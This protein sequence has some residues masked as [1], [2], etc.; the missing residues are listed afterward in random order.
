[1]NYLNGLLIIF[2]LAGGGMFFFQGVRRREGYTIFLYFALIVLG[3]V[4]IFELILSVKFFLF[5]LKGW[6]FLGKILFWGLIGTVFFLKSSIKISDKKHIFWV[7]LLGIVIGLGL[8]MLTK[9]TAAVDWYDP[10]Q[11]I[12]TQYVDLLARNR[13]TRW[14]TQSFYIFGIGFLFY[15]FLFSLLNREKKWCSY[16]VILLSTVLLACQEYLY[17]HIGELWGDGAHLLGG[18]GIFFVVW[19]LH[20]SY[21]RVPSANSRIA[22]TFSWAAI[23]AILVFGV[24]FRLTT[25]GNICGSIISH[26]S[27]SFIRLSGQNVFSL[28]FF[29]SNRPAFI[30]FT[31]KMVGVDPNTNITSVNSPAEDIFVPRQVYPD[32]NCVSGWQTIMSIIS[33]STLAIFLVIKVQSRWLRAVLAALVLGFAY[34]PQL[35]DWDS[36]ILSESLSFSMWALTFALSMEVITR[37]IQNRKQVSWS[38]W[39][40]FILWSITLICWGFSRDTNAYMILLFGIISA[41]LLVIPGIRKLVSVYPLL[42]IVVVCLTSF[43]IQNSLLYRSDRWINPFFNNL[44]V[45]IL[46]YPERE[47]WFIE[48]GMPTPK[49]LYEV[50]NLLSREDK[51]EE[52]A[53]LIAWTIEN[54]S[55]LYTR[56]ILTHPGWSLSTFW[57][58]SQKTF[59]ENQQ[60]FYEPGIELVSPFIYSIGDMFHPMSR[61][62]IIVQIA[63]LVGI[64]GLVGFANLNEHQRGMLIVICIFFIGELG[65]LFVSIHGDALGIVRHALVSVMPLRLNIWILAVFVLDNLNRFPTKI[66]DKQNKVAK[67]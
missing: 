13:P 15:F 66:S 53:E 6:Y 26:D 23:I 31:Y 28:E 35:A 14:L 42:L 19:T 36:V 12:H 24:L 17:A 51:Q 67:P 8:T 49:P 50:V 4:E 32:L 9:I 37:I 27:N 44:N 22:N 40:V 16:L 61:T 46:P 39:L 62:V 52:I 21:E 63:M 2:L 64:I 30:T 7:M 56:Y 11:S 25:Y 10:N 57:R 48:R 41:L 58:L 54:G 65:M 18:F 43:G 33:W 47:S 5:A 34:V 59:S 45:H 3:L 38:T 20:P 55:S 1:M 60:P 29:T